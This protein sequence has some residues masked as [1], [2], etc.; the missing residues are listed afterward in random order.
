[1]KSLMFLL[2][3]V[4]LLGSACSGDSS[5]GLNGQGP[6]AVNLGAAGNYVILA[7]TGIS[8]TGVSSYVGDIGLSPAAASFITGFGLT[9]DGSNTFSTSALVT[10]KV[11]AA[12]Y[13]APTPT[14]L[15]TAV[16]DMQNAYTDA[17][18]RTSPDHT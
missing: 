4:A 6:A 11:W 17:A 1:M 14:N 13:T 5:T 16:L 18:G 3:G 12:D 2:A 9:T 15:T 7:K 8:T 10:G